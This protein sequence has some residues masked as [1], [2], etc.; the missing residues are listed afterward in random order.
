MRSLKKEVPQDLGQVKLVEVKGQFANRDIISSV[1]GSGVV[2]RLALR[3]EISQF[4]GEWCSGN[5]S[6]FG[7]E[8]RRFESFLP[9]HQK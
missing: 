5:T 4:I 9:S 3:A 7:V 1:L 6:A 2:V 8:D